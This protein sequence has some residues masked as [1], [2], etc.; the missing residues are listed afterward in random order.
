MADSQ[1]KGKATGSPAA[2]VLQPSNYNGDPSFYIIFN[3]WYGNNAT[4]WTLFENGQSVGTYPLTDNSPNPQKA[5]S[6]VFTRTNGVYNYVATG[7]NGFGT[8]LSTSYTVTVKNGLPPSGPPNPPTTVA[9]TVV[10]SNQINVS[11][12][13]VANATSY[14]VQ[15]D[16]NVIGTNVTSPFSVTGLS[17]GSTHTFAVQSANASGAG[18]FSTPPATAT[19]PLPPQPPLTP[20]GLA[21]A[22][23]AST[24]ATITWNP[25]VSATGYDLLLDGTAVNDVVSPYS[26][27]GFAPS[28]SHAVQVRSKNAAGASPFSSTV[29]FTTP[30]GTVPP[31]TPTGLAAVAAGSTQINVTW[32]SSAGATSYQLLQDGSTISGVASPYA[33]VGLTAGSTHSFQVRAV[34]SAGASA[35]SAAVAATT[36]AAPAVP[37][38]PGGLAASAVS[39]SSIT[40]SWSASAGATSYSLKIDGSTVV[41]NAVSSYTVNSLADGSTHTFAVS[42]SNASG[43]SAY[44]A[45]VSATTS[46]AAVP[47]VPTGLSVTVQSASQ[48]TVVWLGASGATSYDLLKN[49]TT[50]TSAHTP[51]VDNAVQPLTTYSYSVRG[52]NAA[53]SSA[54][55]AAVSGTTPAAVVN[56][57]LTNGQLVNTALP[58][59]LAY[60]PSWNTPY[61]TVNNA[62]GSPMSDNAVWTAAGAFSQLSG[63]Y[64]HCNLSF[65]QPNFAWKG[66]TANVWTGTGIEFP[67]APDAVLR[68]INIYR[69]LKKKVLLSVGG[70]S[71]GDWTALG[72]EAGKGGPITTALTQII[73][74]LQL[75]GLDVD[76]ESNQDPSPASVALYA[77]C[78][79]TMRAAVDA[80]SGPGAKLLSIAAF[81]TGSDYTAAQ[82]GQPG[83]PGKPSY[84]S[85]SASRERLTFQ[86]KITT[87]IYAGKLV[88][89]LLDLCCCMTYDAGYQFY[90]PMVAFSQYQTLVPASTAVL[91]GVEFAIQSWGGAVITIENAQTGPVGTI[92]LQ[93]Q[94]Q[95]TINQ[96]NSVDNFLKYV[97]TNAINPKSG[98]FNW[99]ATITTSAFPYAANANTFATK[100]AASYGYVPTPP[101]S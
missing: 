5:R 70:A 66:M 76:F 62:D 44:S 57:P 46:S 88:G 4:N 69:Q 59:C 97:K 26:A 92:I 55:S 63:V 36:S 10:S 50:I 80:S 39:S 33:A 34:N 38:I 90:S 89:S 91:I 67:V 42:A 9:A 35:Y 72:A 8:T 7:S 30:A 98:I 82:A 65:A 6:A 96:P 23:T 75:D 28:S 27:S 78:I 64:S 84:W 93:D 14:N 48:I 61:F 95:N 43:S 60:W 17:A 24:S 56:P 86:T 45:A 40:V 85:G 74:D 22:V 37:A 32:S 101:S 83:Y 29:V 21:A 53:G 1:A 94:Y 25:A 16:G 49:G 73:N 20:T 13:A 81:S 47:A 71:Y 18:P 77:N 58:F 12:N 31:L 99:E 100:V 79:Q 51:Y 3:I 41:S 19:T 15:M 54:W 52:T 2:G 87:G 68:I 11:W